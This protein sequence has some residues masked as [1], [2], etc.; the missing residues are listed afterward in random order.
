MGN[1]SAVAIGSMPWLA[2]N[3]AVVRMPSWIQ[4]SP[5]GRQAMPGVIVQTQRAACRGLVSAQPQLPAGT[6]V[7]RS[8]HFEVDT[9]GVTR[10][11]A[12]EI[13]ERFAA[14]WM[15]AGA[16]HRVVVSRVSSRGLEGVHTWRELGGDPPSAPTLH[17]GKTF[18]RPIRKLSAV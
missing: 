6:F 14:N 1:G 18:S 11:D 15:L 12:A 17:G 13:R 3:R 7:H 8:V 4:P 2:V 16:L 9:L 5:I 10:C